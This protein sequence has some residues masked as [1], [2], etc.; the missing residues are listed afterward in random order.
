MAETIIRGD[1]WRAEN[2]RR[3]YPFSDRATRTAVSGYVIPDAAIVDAALY[4]VPGPGPS[5][6]LGALAVDATAVRLTFFDP[7]AG[8]VAYGTAVIAD[9][10]DRVGLFD[11]LGLVPV[12]LVVLGRGGAAALAAA[13]FG[14]V[15]FTRAAGELACGVRRPT[16]DGGV[17]G[18]R[19]PTGEVLTGT[20]YLTGGP[21]VAFS[22]DPENVRVP[23]AGLVT[24]VNTLVVVDVV[25]DPLFRRAACGTDEAAYQAPRPVR[26]V[27]V[28]SDD[29]EFDVE[30][31]A[32]GDFAIVA[33]DSATDRPSLRIDSAADEVTVRHAVPGV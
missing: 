32:A 26:T 33:G 13:G 20:V 12:G 3:A 8:P 19:T 18:V 16:A 5:A 1:E 11:A 6:Y 10:P 22:V 17:R 25:G 30:L 7:T 9:D 4:G 24:E 31:D 27:R 21:G 29:G 2:A 14:T 28:V 23:V 15:S